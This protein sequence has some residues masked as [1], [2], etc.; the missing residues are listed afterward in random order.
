MWTFYINFDRWTNIIILALL[1]NREGTILRYCTSGIKQQCQARHTLTISLKKNTIFH[2][3]STITFNTA[4]WLTQGHTSSFGSNTLGD[5]RQQAWYDGPAHTLAHRA[6]GQACH[7]AG[8]SPSAS[9]G[10]WCCQWCWRHQGWST[11]A[12]R[13]GCNSSSLQD[14]LVPKYRKSL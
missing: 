8:S 9:P 11:M 7:T 1:A 14:T 13:M 10:M 5:R 2:F 4:W 12:R 6:A 3:V